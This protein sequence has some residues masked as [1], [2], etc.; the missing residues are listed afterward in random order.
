MKS[1][2]KIWAVLVAMAL[3]IA[4]AFKAV[5]G[6]RGADCPAPTNVATQY[7]EFVGYAIKDTLI[8][9]LYAA[10]QGMRAVAQHMGVPLAPVALYAHTTVANLWTPAVWL[11]GLVERLTTRLSL[12]NS[13]ILVTHPDIK[14]A[15]E[16]GGVAVE[17]PFVQEPNIADS[18]QQENNALTISNLASGRQTAAVLNRR[19]GIGATALSKGVSGIDPLASALDMI[20][21]IRLRQRQTTLLS[22][23]RGVFGFSDGPG[24]GTAA[25]KPLRRDIFSETGA[26]PTADKLFSSDEYVKTLGLMG[27]VKDTLDGC[28]IVCHSAIEQAMTLQEDIATVRDSEGKARVIMYK[29][30]K[31]FVSDQLV[32]AG[33]TSGFVYDTY[34]FNAGSVAYGEKDQT[35]EVGD[36]ATFYPIVDT[37]FNNKGFA[38]YTRFILHPQGAKWG[39]TPAGQSATNAE[40]ATA[41]NWTLAFA[42]AKNAKIVCLRTNG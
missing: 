11:K 17:I 38:D 1:F 39:G 27:E 26:S 14:A 34:I 36:I 6:S 24:A 4:G 16:G 25:F 3:L 31:V 37:S 28:V 10:D 20:T 33:T 8:T 9:G 22:I 18:P 2:T 29:G 19:W 12:I 35:S 21:D 30:A 7:L 41:A 42:D 5:T 15:A 40:L 13:G 23:L 32:R